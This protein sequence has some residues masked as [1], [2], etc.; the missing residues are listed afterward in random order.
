MK[1]KSRAKINISLGILGKLKNKLHRIESTFFFLNLHDDIYIKKINKKKHKIIFFGKFS[2]GI[3]K[4]N[5]IS[6]LLK[7][8]EKK[9]KL[10]GQKYLIKVNKKIPQK[11]GMGGGSMN[12]SSLFKYFIKNLKLKISPN[13]MLEITSEIG[14]DVI[15]GIQNNNSI[16]FGDG[17][18]IKNLNNQ[19]FSNL[20]NDLEEPAFKKYPALKKL[21]I[22]M[23]KLN[24]I[25]FVRMTG[26]GSTM[27][28]YFNSKKA[29]LN[30]TKILSKK[31]KKYLC[32]LSKTI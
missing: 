12:A 3:G 8:L 6:N 28:G 19:F 32:I 17:K 13:E 21:K 23:E 30:A 22:Y 31:Y 26:S 5:S 27:I 14:A 24:K 11:S 15:I 9:N 18:I 7:L 4:T 16:L 25:L 29:A 1:I 10:S 2:R 20:R